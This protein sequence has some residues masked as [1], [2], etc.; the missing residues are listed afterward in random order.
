MKIVKRL[1]GRIFNLYAQINVSP[2]NNLIHLGSKYSGY[3]VPDNYLNTSS[4]CYCVGAGVDISLDVE[5]ATNYG[6]QVFVF[7]PMPY[8]L[9]HFNELVNKTSKGQQ[10]A[11]GTG[12]HAYVYKINGE[13]LKTI[14]FV[15]TGV[16]DEKKLLKFYSPATQNY[17][18]HSITN[19]Q[20]T[21]QYIEAPVDTLVNIMQKLGHSHIDLL[22]IE[23]EGAE[24]TV[25]DNVL[26]DKI[27]VKIILVEFDEFYHR[28]GKNLATLRRIKKSSDKL[29]KAGYKLVHTVSYCKKVFVRD[30]IFEMLDNRDNRSKGVLEPQQRRL[31][32]TGTAG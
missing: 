17:A 29:L 19:L 11:I 2:L 1:P 30:D 5:L 15:K 16:W 25:I 22:K 8:A 9:D 26:N 21:D 3:Y 4:I 6:A 24:Y 32:T 20:N 18:G 23:I 27:D 13:Q 14:Q 31:E 7:D 28:K 10:L 12:E